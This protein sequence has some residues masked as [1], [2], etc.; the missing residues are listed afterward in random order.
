M[1]VDMSE[2]EAVLLNLNRIFLQNKHKAWLW[3]D[4]EEKRSRHLM[5][6]T[7]YHTPDKRIAGFISGNVA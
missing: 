6:C 3:E 5:L 4:K 2:P 7:S 1:C